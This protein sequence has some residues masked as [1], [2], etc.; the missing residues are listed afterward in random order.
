MKLSQRQ[1]DALQHMVDHCHKTIELSGRILTL[2]HL[3]ANWEAQYILV[4]C[5]EIIGE[6][7][8]RLGPQFHTTYPQVPWR[9]IIGMRNALIHGYDGVD[10][11]TLWETAT[12]GVPELLTQIEAIRKSA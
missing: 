5:I 6:A 2:E 9:L 8:T 4:R 10:L 7:A 3:E 12:R 1:H 11:P